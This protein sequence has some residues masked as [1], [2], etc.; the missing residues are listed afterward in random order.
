MNINFY[1]AKMNTPEKP[2]KQ[3][4]LLGD[5]SFHTDFMQQLSRML[6][7]GFLPEVVT[8]VSR[9]KVW[10]WELKDTRE[11]DKGRFFFQ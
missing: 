4:L 6:T 9:D 2:H 3:L 5:M 11:T 10:L 1:F 7:D 8:A